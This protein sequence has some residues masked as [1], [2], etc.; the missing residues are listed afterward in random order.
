[1]Y[2]VFGGR[3]YFALL[4]THIQTSF[5]KCYNTFSIKL[6]STQLLDTSSAVDGWKDKMNGKQN[7]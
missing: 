7:K 6:A 2:I 1:M 3:N 5:G 4:M